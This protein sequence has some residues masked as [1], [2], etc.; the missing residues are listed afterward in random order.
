LQRYFL[1]GDKHNY[2]ITEWPSTENKFMEELKNPD[3][4]KNAER[5]ELMDRL[6]EYTASFTQLLYQKKK[7]EEY[8][9]SKQMIKLII[10]ELAA[11]ESQ[12]KLCHSSSVE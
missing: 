4:I 2:C 3:Q 9:H 6:A 12:N 11:R 10:T 8:H 7:N 5:S 1:I